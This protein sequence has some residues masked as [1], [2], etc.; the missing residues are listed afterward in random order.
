MLV[1][2]NWL[3]QYVDID[4]ITPEELAEKITKSGIEVD[5]IEHIA[6]KSTNLVTGYVSSCEKHPDADKLNLCQ[7][8]VGE[9]ETLQI[10]CGAPNVAQGQKVVV[11]KPGARLPGGIK[12]KKAKLRGIV[13]NGMICSLKELGFEEKYI[14]KNFADGI[15]VFAD[16]VEVGMPVGELLNLNDVVLEFDLTPNRSDCLSMIGVAFE[17][18]AILDQPVK[19]PEPAV[20]AIADSASE[21]ISVSVIAG[22]LCKYYSAY[23]IKDV[24]IK[25][26][27]L[28]MQNYLQAAGIR[29]INNVV[30]ITNYVLLE[31]G[32]PLHAFDYDRLAS[33]EIVVRR[34]KDGESIVTLDDVE[35]RLTAENLVITNGSKP[36]ALAGVMGGA[37]T[38]V[39]DDTKTIL[40]EAAHFNH[41]A[42][43]ATVKTTGLRSEASTRYEKKA[44]DIARINEAGLRACQLLEQY[45]SG[46][47]LQ[48]AAEVDYREVKRPEIAM[49]TADVN[50]RL[51]TRMSATE[52]ENIIQRLRFDYER[53]DAHFLVKAPSRRGDIQ[54]YEDMLEEIA[55][56]YGY[57]NLPF[58]LPKGAAQAGALT[59]T[60]Q[61]KRRMKQYLQGIGMM[62]TVTYSLTNSDFSKRLV[63]PEVRDMQ[64][65]PISVSMPMT[66]DHRYLRLSILPELLKSAAYNRARKQF[67]IAY[68]EMGSVFIT[69]EEELTEQPLE[70]LRLSG[71]LC[72]NWV[73]HE[74]QQEIKKIDFY[75]VKG[76]VEGLADYLRLDLDYTAEALPDMHPGRCAVLRTGTKEIG[77][78]G[79]I[80][81]KLAKEMDLKETYVFDLNLS[82]IIAQHHVEPAYHAISKYPSVTRDVAFV[83]DESVVA[84]DVEK[85]IHKTGQPLVN[86]THVFDV[87]KGENLSEG[88]K[89]LAYNIVFQHPEKTLKDEEVDESFQAIISAVQKQFDAEIRS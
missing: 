42:V 48:G 58:T 56:L 26:S 50:D 18:A 57:D 23:M 22:D 77:F 37:E 72:G 53:T 82:E 9:G 87:Y 29:P 69:Q 68:F 20:E 61:L 16:D 63:S 7:V 24:V 55:R 38:Q 49:D 80:H 32:Q 51:G 6:E 75:I 3:R 76:I 36:V 17:V 4:N 15:Y 64:P 44:I 40:L 79:Q 5:H 2:L 81:P 67:D 83:L 73:Q 41:S 86:E 30:D 89:S 14:P 47:V 21:Y 43:R 35:R 54:I 31:Y 19:L 45:A 65:K 39:E 11:A 28:W 33:K 12:I 66:E 84:G 34:A 85:L 88:K 8:D 52:I 1:S 78:I 62:E 71:V 25:P 70:Q 27:P 74:W 10:I 60:Q 13:S 59:E 46:K